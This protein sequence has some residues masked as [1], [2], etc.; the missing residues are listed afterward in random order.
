MSGPAHVPASEIRAWAELTGTTPERW[1]MLALM[2]LDR[3]FVAI[4]AEH[5]EM[6]S[7]AKMGGGDG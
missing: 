4:T 6:Q 1:E 3:E 2:A 5:L 7:A